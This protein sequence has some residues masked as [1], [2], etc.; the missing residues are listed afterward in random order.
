M[1]EK[2]KIR[3]PAG[4]QTLPA[5]PTSQ[6]QNAGPS[7]QYFQGNR[8]VL[9]NTWRPVL[10]EHSDDIGESWADAAARATEGIQ[11]SGFL[12]RVLE[13]DTG[14]VVGQGLRFS[15][16]PDI[17]ALGWT[18]EEASD[19]SR[20]FESMFR[21]WCNNPIECDAAGK[22]TFGRMQQA[23]YSSYKAF[24]EV[25]ALTPIIDR[26]GAITSTKIKLIPPYRLDSATDIMSGVTQGVRTD[27]WGFPLA[28]R[29][30]KFNRLWG[31]GDFEEVRARDADG[32]PNVLHIFE[33]GISTTRG[34]SPLAPI[35]KVVR[36]A[37][38]YA[39]AT[40][41]TALIQ[42]IFAA[43]I[44]TSMPGITAFEGL[45]TGQDG[46]GGA[47]DLVKLAE[48]QGAW[49]D[50]S[51]INLTQHGRIAHLFPNEKLN[52]TEAK[53]PGQQYDHFMGWLMREIAA[54]CGVTYESATGDFRGATYSSIRMGGAQEWLGVTRRRSNVIVP[55]C[56]EVK[57]LWLDE[58]I[59]SGR[60][61][62]PKRMGYMNFLA[63]KDAIARGSWSGPAQPQAD[64]FKAARA[65]QVLKDIG[66]VTLKG[67][68]E[69]YGRDWED[70]ARQKAEENRLY[71]ELGLPL[72]HAPETLM[73][74][75]EG[76]DAEL[77]AVQ[78]PPEPAIPNGNATAAAVEEEEME[79]E[80][81]LGS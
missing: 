27:G 41:T 16:S 23:A 1:A 4:R 76:Q 63:M 29:I 55:F 17:D 42:T 35:L 26:P 19:F 68:G 22:N 80:L 31:W 67:I 7:A 56:E 36:Q 59:Y 77:D 69:A 37:D 28:Y 47:L 32:R 58:A 49:Y 75:K 2:P 71:D 15:S 45:M 14:S 39:D 65:F 8:N 12:T 43:T 18:V 51:D 33:G 57:M 24:G 48:A 74:S 52:F 5:L 66:A 79:E 3:V 20:K 25:L 78:N 46:V 54:G 60:L 11:N 44:E 38:Q 62:L 53:A 30:R 34:I 13:V 72:P 50:S 70:D 21:A 64:D 81:N 73:E 9:L 40:L 10:R 61:K 6:G